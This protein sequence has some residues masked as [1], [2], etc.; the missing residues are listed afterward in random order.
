[1]T[2]IPELANFRLL[3]MPKEAI[4]LSALMAVYNRENPS[5]D[6]SKKNAIAVMERL[7][8]F[9]NAKTLDDLTQEALLAWRRDIEGDGKLASAATRVAY[10][11]RIKTIISFGLKVGLDEKQIRAALDR[12]SV[13]WTAEPLPSVQP[14]PISRVDF[15]KLLAA[16]TGS[17]VSMAAV[18][19]Q[20]LYVYRGGLRAVVE[21]L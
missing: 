11:G 19:T 6:R 12:C 4:R 13:L 9:T 20:P 5:N 7:M 1:M 21:R 18:G 10:Y 2:G 16:G 8:K 17:M 15:H 14:R 3:G